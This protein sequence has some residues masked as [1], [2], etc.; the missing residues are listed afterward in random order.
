MEN[1]GSCRGFGYIYI[2]IYIDYNTKIYHAQVVWKK[3]YD[4]SVLLDSFLSY[5][6]MFFVF[7]DERNITYLAMFLI[8]QTSSR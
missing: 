6:F 2:Y 8:E 4:T 1:C 7:L 5:I 3:S